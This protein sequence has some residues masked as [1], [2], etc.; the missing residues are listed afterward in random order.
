[1]AEGTKTLINN[2]GSDITVWLLIREG[3]SPEDEGAH[4]NFDLGATSPYNQ[5]EAVYEGYPGSEGYVFL[6]GLLVEWADGGDK[7]G[8]SLRVVSRGDTWDDTL[9]KNDIITI[10]S[11]S[12][13]QL[14]ASGSN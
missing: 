12:A 4:E 1:M 11:V 8:V 7:V 3:D 6:N 5:L 2:T 10:N 14:S 9:N 13:G